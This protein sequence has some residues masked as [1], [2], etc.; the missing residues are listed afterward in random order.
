MSNSNK[1][2]SWHNSYSVVTSNTIISGNM[3]CHRCKGKIQGDYLIQNRYCL[4][5]R[6][7]EHDEAYLFHRECSSG[8]KKWAEF[9]IIK[10][11]SIEAE[12]I[13]KGQI[14]EV[15]LLIHKYQLTENDLFD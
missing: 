15:K 10:A 7:N 2:E 5:R 14:E 6:G 12:I 9:D 1:K 11:K 4:S 3:I 13:R 8:N